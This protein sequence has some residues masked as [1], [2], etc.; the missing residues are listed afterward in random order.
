M[1]RLNK[2]ISAAG[3]A[4]RRKADELIRAGRVTVDGRA[5]SIGTQVDA[6]AE[7]AVDGRPL[8]LNEEKT[9][10]AY[11]KPRGIVCTFEER[12]R[13]NLSSAFTYPVRV[14]YAGRLDK[15]SEGLLLLTDDGD[16]IDALMRARYGHE[17]E[18]IVR[19]DRDVTAELIRH[20]GGGIYLPALD[21][22]TRKAKVRQSGAREF[23]IVLTQGLNRQIRRMCEALGCKVL[24]LKRIRVANITLGALKSGQYRPLSADEVR[25]LQDAVKATSQADE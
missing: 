1:I 14:T 24:S 12:E 17:K 3:Y 11:Y 5:A 18:Y 23:H 7:V 6:G 9:Y 2:Y 20:L 25:I 4:S 13:H 10:L 22:T 21:V 16:L 19:I 8:F 15:D